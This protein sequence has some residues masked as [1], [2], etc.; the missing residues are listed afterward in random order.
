[1]FLFLSNIFLIQVFP[2]FHLVLVVRLKQENLDHYKIFYSNSLSLT[3]RKANT[4]I[5]TTVSIPF[6][7][8][9]K[10]SKQFAASN[11]SFSFREIFYYHLNPTNF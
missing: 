3:T 7:N 10:N 1:M 5:P 8:L 2:F 11:A 6:G 9:F 4:S